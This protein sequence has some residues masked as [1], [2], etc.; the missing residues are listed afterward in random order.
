MNMKVSVIK[1][2]ADKYGGMTGG[3]VRKAMRAEVLEGF[4]LRYIYFIDPAYRARLTVPEL[5]YSE[6]KARGATMYKG[7]RPTGETGEID[8][9]PQTNAEIGGASP[10]VS[11]LQ[12]CTE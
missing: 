7:Q 2:I 12:E 9:A 4:Q 3:N 5:P 10:T 8:S 11:L 6:I 1:K